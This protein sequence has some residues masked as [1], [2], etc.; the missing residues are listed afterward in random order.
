[1]SFP[2]LTILNLNTPQSISD[3]TWT[4]VVFDN[5]EVDEDGAGDLVGDAHRITVPGGFTQAMFTFYTAWANNSSGKRLVSVEKN[6]GGVEGAGT[7]VGAVFNTAVN[8]TGVEVITKWLA[9]TPG[10]YFEFWV[11]QDSGGA[12]NLSGSAV[13]GGPTYAMAEFKA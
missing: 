7:V 9:V 5:E 3:S 10:D 4:R 12:R 1:M 8:E 11:W 13:F 6:G 2:S